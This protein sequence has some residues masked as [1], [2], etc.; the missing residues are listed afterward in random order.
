MDFTK[1]QLREALENTRNLCGEVMTQNA[2]LKARNEFLEQEIERKNQQ[3]D[4]L[5]GQINGLYKQISY[6]FSAK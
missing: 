4:D 2:H 1:K 5:C 3:I 6:N